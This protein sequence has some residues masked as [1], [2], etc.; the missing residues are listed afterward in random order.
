MCGIVG[1]AGTVTIDQ[2]KAFQQM[3]LVNATRGLHGAGVATLYGW[4]NKNFFNIAKTEDPSSIWVWTKDYDSAVNDFGMK[5]LAGHSRYATQGGITIEN[6][7]PF[8]VKNKIVGM[9]NGT[10]NGHFELR[11]K[12]A[13]DSEALINLIAKDGLKVALTKVYDKAYSP[14]YALVIIDLNQDSVSIIRNDKR[15]MFLCKVKDDVYWASQA[16]FLEFGLSQIGV[17][18]FVIEELP[19]HALF[20]FYPYKHGKDRLKLIPN[21]FTPPAPKTVV[22]TGG[23]G[24]ARP[25]FRDEDYDLWGGWGVPYG[26]TGGD[27]PAEDPKEGVKAGHSGGSNK[28]TGKP[29]GTTSSTSTFRKNER[30][31]HYV[32]GPRI[33]HKGYVLNTL[34]QK[35]CAICGHPQQDLEKVRFSADTPDEFYCYD[36]ADNLEHHFNKKWDDCLKAVPYL[37]QEV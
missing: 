26:S 16:N 28:G 3:M 7:H 6:N 20:K 4:N 1:V 22:Y 35:G 23:N 21:Y 14:A 10:I 37:A 15:P 12:F 5:I 27:R 34:L 11:D 2:K 31:R 29:S 36:C 24:Q 19:P 8:L 18:D 13:T 9:H 32:I 25:P 30:T 17:K 33:L